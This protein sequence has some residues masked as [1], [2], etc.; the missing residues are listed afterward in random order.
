MDAKVAI[1]AG[2]GAQHPLFFGKD[3]RWLVG[4]HR[5]SQDVDIFRGEATV[6]LGLALFA[7]P[8]L[9]VVQL[10]LGWAAISA[11]SAIRSLLA[12]EKKPLGQLAT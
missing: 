12:S 7:G 6:S 9:V 5:R 4:Q 8:R 1:E 11:R 10:R 3:R 2:I